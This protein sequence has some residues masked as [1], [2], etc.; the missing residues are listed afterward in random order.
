MA[1]LGAKFFVLLVKRILV[2][3]G[4]RGWTDEDDCEAVG[5]HAFARGG[6][7]SF[8]DGYDAHE[9]AVQECRREWQRRRMAEEF[10]RLRRE[11]GTRCD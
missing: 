4:V 7:A 9:R 5:L 1:L 6:Q 10:E 2:W 11:R 3:E 8:V